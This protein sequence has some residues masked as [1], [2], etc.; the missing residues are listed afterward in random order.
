MSD[1]ITIGQLYDALPP[2]VPVNLGGIT[3]TRWPDDDPPT[4]DVCAQPGRRYGDG[5][6]IF[7]ADCAHDAGISGEA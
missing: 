7:C 6:H 4:C 3:F 2:G 5:G 1:D